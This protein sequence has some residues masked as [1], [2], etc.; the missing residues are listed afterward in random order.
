MI[1]RRTT[2]AQICQ[3][4]SHAFSIMRVQWQKTVSHSHTVNIDIIIT[5]FTEIMLKGKLTSLH[6]KMP[7]RQF[8]GTKHELVL[9]I[10]LTN[11]VQHLQLR[12][13]LLTSPN[14]IP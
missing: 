13:Q 2:I 8:H 11:F 12:L 4:L 3:G 1:G 6:I 10:V 5:F 7:D 9:Y 14:L